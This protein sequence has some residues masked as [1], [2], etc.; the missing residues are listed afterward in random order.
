MYKNIIILIVATVSFLYSQDELDGCSRLKSYRNLYF[1][2]EAPTRNQ[3]DFD[4]KFYDLD[5]DIYEDTETI[6]GSVGV[7]ASSLVDNLD[8][9]ELNFTYGMT[10]DGVSDVDGNTLAHSYTN[11]NMLTI[12]LS[13][14]LNIGDLAHIIIQYHGSPEAT[15]FGSFGFDYYSGQPMIWTLSEPY[16]ARDWWPCKDTPT[17][18]AD[19]VDISI[20]VSDYLTV[21]SNGLLDEV[22]TDNGRTTFHWKER[23]PIV[24]YLVSL[25]IYPYTHFSGVFT[26][27]GGITM[28]LEYYVFPNHYNSVQET[29]AMTPDMI[30]AFSDRFGLYPFIDEK[31]GHA[32]FV[33]GGGMEHQTLTSMGGWSQYL[34]AH[35]LAHQWWGDMITCA[36][37]HH[38]WLNE[39]FATYSQAMWYEMRDNSIQSLHNDMQTK[40][41]LGGGTIYVTDTTSVG[42]IF[43]SNL[44]Y[45][46]GAWVM[47]MLRHIVGDPMFFEG[48]QA[49]GDLYRFEST[50]T[51]DFKN[52]M[53]DISGIELDAFFERWI[54]GHYYPIYESTPQYYS[55][56]NGSYYLAI[57]VS[58]NQTSPLFSMPIDIQIETASETVVH[59][60]ENSQS[61]QE[62]AFILNELPQSVIIDP[63]EWIL[64]EATHH[65]PSYV[66]NVL[67]GDLNQDSALNVLD[68]VQGVNLIL[69]S[70]QEYFQV[71]IFDMNSDGS[72]NILDIVQIVSVIIGDPQQE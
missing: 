26:Y 55:S 62:Y 57:T 66:G 47:H 36:N 50:V 48:L 64:K 71:W 19:S 40:R 27:E 9:V 54:Y 29:Y 22:S 45:K 8:H 38:I 10:I 14:G 16:G 4:V 24:T 42:S 2:N 67:T 20:T 5:L 61:S 31:Y 13:S 46:K 69:G 63:D 7:L 11:D 39:G 33:W 70:N 30:G 25:A 35:E 52:V 68:V 44:V 41:Y 28:P 3:Q 72:G 43:N 34:I 12:N 37:F 59:Q 18:K 6:S 60:V 15:G 23:Y 65:N 56:T 32:E 21:A 53:E 49:Y 1:S 51:D 58:Q 17:D